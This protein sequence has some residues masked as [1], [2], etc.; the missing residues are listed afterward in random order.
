MFF[1]FCFS[2]IF[3]FESNLCWKKKLK[4]T[5]PFSFHTIYTT[6]SIKKWWTAFHVAFV[7]INLFCNL[8]SFKTT[9]PCTLSYSQMESKRKKAKG[10]KH[11]KYTEKR[12]TA[13]G[14][15]STKRKSSFVAFVEN[16]GDDED[17]KQNSSW[18]KL[19]VTWSVSTRCHALT[20]F[21]NEAVMWLR[22]LLFIVRYRG[23]ML[24]GGPV[25]MS[26]QD[27]WTF[28]II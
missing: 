6:F 23:K 14:L 24:V 2:S 10:Q 16:D 21:E 17:D 19:S 26:L 27:F 7:K 25:A 18:S 9:S 20:I 28:C 4:L 12:K 3:F 13:C 5:A 22:H 1:E 15:V 8:S 11:T